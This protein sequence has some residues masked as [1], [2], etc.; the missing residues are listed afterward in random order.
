VLPH[1]VGENRD[2]KVI[3]YAP[4]RFWVMALFLDE[5]SFGLFRSPDLK[6]WTR[7]QTLTL[8]GSECP[9]FFPMPIAGEPGEERWIFMAANGHYLVGTFDGSWFQAETGSLV[10]DH[11]ANYYAMQSFSDIPASDGR[12]IQIAWMA[13]G[14]YPDMPFNQQMSIPSVLTLHRGPEGL[15]LRRNPISE[16]ESLRTETQQWRD[17]PVPSGADPL[18]GLEGDLFDITAEVECRDA[19]AVGFRIRGA[20]IKY[21]AAD[22][23]L[24]CLGRHAAITGNGDGVRLRILVDRSSIE[25]FV[26]D[27]R[28]SL[29]FC[30]T[31]PPAD[32]SLAFFAEGSDVFVRSLE[33]HRLRS[34]WTGAVEA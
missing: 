16:I 2:P 7:I 33:V 21:V 3:W 15:S 14:A 29:A 23:A 26:N 18:S 13:G 1:I 8:S 25:I 32:R 17:L 31:P 30:F 5:E 11:G 22:R 28:E 10:L 27:G 6:R 24:S 20:E 34:A 12:R 19:N 9:D 4:G